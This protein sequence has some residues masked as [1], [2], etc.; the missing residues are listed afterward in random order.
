[1]DLVEHAGD[2][3]RGELD[4]ELQRAEG[5]DDEHDAYIGPGTNGKRDE[6]QR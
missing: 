2:G 3:L 1:V 6:I 4:G 5:V